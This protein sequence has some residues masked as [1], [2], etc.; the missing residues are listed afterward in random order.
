MRLAIALLAGL[1]A[2]IVV[3]TVW[4]A[5]LVLYERNQLVV[6]LAA[7]VAVLIAVVVIDF[8]TELTAPKS[9]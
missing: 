7:G 8:L 4:S 2:A 1:S 3:G 5:A 9:G 6:P